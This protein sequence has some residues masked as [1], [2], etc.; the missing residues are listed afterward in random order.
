MLSYFY[1]GSLIWNV[2]Q[3]ADNKGA[4]IVVF[5]ELKAID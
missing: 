4:N 2:V 3:E 5:A 1:R